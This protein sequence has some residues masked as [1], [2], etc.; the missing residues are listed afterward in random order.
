M[1]QYIPYIIL[2]V[3]LIFILVIAYIKMR[4]RFWTLQ[5]VFHV[6]DFHYYLFPPGIINPDLPEKTISCHILKD[7]I[8]PVFSLF[9]MKMNF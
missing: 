6:Y 2:I 4:F 8:H 7:I 9:I 5:P 1:Y 3:V